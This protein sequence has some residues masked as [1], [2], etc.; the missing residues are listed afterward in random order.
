MD[1]F[2]DVNLENGL[3]LHGDPEFRDDDE[4]L[5][6]HNHARNNFRESESVGMDLGDLP[7]TGRAIGQVSATHFEPYF[8]SFRSAESDSF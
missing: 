8:T 4:Q 7:D 3:L 1:A 2:S 6:L 5:P